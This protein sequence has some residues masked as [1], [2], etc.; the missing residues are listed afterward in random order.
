M[1]KKIKDLTLDEIQKFCEKYYDKKW[2]SC[3]VFKKGVCPICFG[4]IDEICVAKE[5]ERE[6]EVDD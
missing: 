2:E 5:M 4:S 1:K 3:A 6:V